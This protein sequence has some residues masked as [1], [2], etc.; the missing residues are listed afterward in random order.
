MGDH[1][2]SRGS[3]RIRSACPPG[4]AG[5]SCWEVAELSCGRP[6]RCRFRSRS[7][8]QPG[9]EATAGE[10]SGPDH[11]TSATLTE[12]ASFARRRIAANRPRFVGEWRR[13]ICSIFDENRTDQEATCRL[14]GRC[15]RGIGSGGE[16]AVGVAIASGAAFGPG[17][18]EVEVGPAV[19][20]DS[21]GNGGVR[22]VLFS[23]K[24]ER[25]RK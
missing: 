1:G 3:I 22:L 5:V 6:F 2:V 25:I 14:R 24:I 20:G 11:P 21:L 23:S 17:Q 13:L 10:S 7:P 12:P 4:S 9:V 15:F 8:R 18:V 16:F 19:R